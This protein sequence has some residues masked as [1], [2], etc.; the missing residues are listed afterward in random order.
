[1]LYEICVSFTLGRDLSTHTRWTPSGGQTKPA[2]LA[3]GTKEEDY[4]LDDRVII[5]MLCVK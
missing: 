5:I 2:Y 3:G 4:K 1:M